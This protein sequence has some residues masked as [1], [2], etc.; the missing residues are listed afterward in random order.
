M[1][2]STEEFVQR[3]KEGLYGENDLVM[4]IME[5]LIHPSQTLLLDENNLSI[6]D[7]LNGRFPLELVPSIQAIFLDWNLK[8]GTTL[9]KIF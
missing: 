2:E 8:L 5:T 9:F 7:I 1:N 6:S 4:F 3:V